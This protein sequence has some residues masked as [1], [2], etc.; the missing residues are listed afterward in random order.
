[1][2]KYKIFKIAEQ[3]GQVLLRQV[4]TYNIHVVVY[5]EVQLKMSVSIS[6]FINI[7]QIHIANIFY[8]IKYVREK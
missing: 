7:F 5:D 8:F 4:S 1:M 6:E 2:H 3:C